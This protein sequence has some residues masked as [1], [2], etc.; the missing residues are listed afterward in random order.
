[1]TIGT[2]AS[3]I[4]PIGII[5]GVLGGSL[6]TMMVGQ[7]IA[8]IG[9]GAAFTAALRL[10]FPLAAEN[11]RAGIVSSIYVVSYVGLGVPIVIAGELIESLG[12]VSTIVWYSAATMLLALIS[13]GQQRLLER[14]GSGPATNDEPAPRIPASPDPGPNRRKQDIFRCQQLNP[15][16]FSSPAPPVSSANN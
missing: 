11:Q 12:L 6:V 9:F 5:C 7:A 16:A 13:L 10:L 4:G 3:I 14:K 1:M 2:Y 8:G 15:C